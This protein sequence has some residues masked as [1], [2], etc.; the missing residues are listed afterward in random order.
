MLAQHQVARGGPALDGQV[1][2]HRFFGR[3]ESHHLAELTAERGLDYDVFANRQLGK[4]AVVEVVQL[5]D[6]FE[7]DAGDGLFGEVRGGSHREFVIRHIEHSITWRCAAVNR[8]R[9]L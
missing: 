7:A 5:A 3:A 8:R 6:G 4:G 9:A 1:L 2:L